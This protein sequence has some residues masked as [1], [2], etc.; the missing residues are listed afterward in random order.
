MKK[1]LL[2]ILIAFS[3]FTG[4][5]GQESEP[6]K[7][8]Y[9]FI[10]EYHHQTYIIDAPNKL[11]KSQQT[12]TLRNADADKV[13]LICF[14][15]HPDLVIDRMSI[16]DTLNN[17]FPIKSWQ[18]N[19][20][21]KIYGR[22]DYPVVAVK[23]AEMI[24]PDQKI[25]FNIDY[26]MKPEGVKL[27]PERMYEF[28]VSP[29]A[30][31]AISPIIGN[32][33]F[34]M[35]N[36]NSPYTMILKYPAGNISCVPGNLI[37]SVREGNTIIDTYTHE[38]P[39]VPTFAVAPYKKIIRESEKLKVIYYFYPH[40]QFDERMA[41]ETFRVVRLYF[42][43]FGDNGTSTYKF[44][45]VGEFNS[46]RMNGENKGST[47]FYPD[48]VSR[49]YRDGVEGR[50]DYMKFL[51]HEVFHNWNLFYVYWLD[52]YREW[53]CEGGANFICAWATEQIMGKD[54]GRYVRYQF[55]KR[56]IDQKGWES[57]ETLKDVRKNGVSQRALMYAYGALVWEQLER[58]I[59]RE[60]LFA[61]LGHFYR[62]NGFKQTGYDDL[63]RSLG[64]FSDTDIRSFLKPWF[65]Q[66][67][68]IT[69]SIKDVKVRKTKGKFLTSVNIDAQLNSDYEIF[70]SIGY[71][72]DPEGA[73]MLKPVHIQGEN[74]HQVEFFSDK[75]P[76]F[77]Q[78]DP[79]YI[80]PVV[81]QDNMIWENE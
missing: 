70:T 37:S 33:P 23:M 25:L 13:S 1:Q 4:V 41:D 75:K 2:P 69:L 74:S 36:D 48:F 45:T 46:Q 19:G 11:F 79:E 57:P 68:T 67:A 42:D 44:A 54:A 17:D 6:L 27:S 76:V 15:M 14:L 3:L 50:Y 73:L 72:T 55:A 35:K 30:T 58:K 53:F 43:H 65:T 80:V 63:L 56:F 32:S 20:T 39:N 21:I 66:N 31:Y 26:T 71:R 9:H 61:G 62:Q 22:Y 59:G 16:T 60:P 78:I 24:M 28:A 64:R 77:I 81:C 47:I 8:A 49:H 38:R 34:F 12:I 29:K 52:D 5:Y 10:A 40:E 18:Y 7:N 51:S